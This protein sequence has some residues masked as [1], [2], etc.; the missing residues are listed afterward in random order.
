MGPGG[1]ALLRSQGEPGGLEWHQLYCAGNQRLWETL[2]DLSWLEV[3][4]SAW[5]KIKA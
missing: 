4:A 2:G 1:A 3:Q 5:G